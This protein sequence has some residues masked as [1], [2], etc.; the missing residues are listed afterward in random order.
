MFLV[1]QFKW[2]HERGSL[3]DATRPLLKRKDVQFFPSN[4]PFG[5]LVLVSCNASQ[6]CAGSI[7]MGFVANPAVP[8]RIMPR[9]TDRKVSKWIVGHVLN[10]SRLDINI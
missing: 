4:L 9:D 7:Q 3:V 10:P 2:G 8:A 1:D 6:F 5:F